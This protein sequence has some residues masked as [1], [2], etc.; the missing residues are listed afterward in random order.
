MRFIEGHNNGTLYLLLL[1]RNRRAVLFNLNIVVVFTFRDRV[2]C[3]FRFN[4]ALLLYAL[5]STSLSGL[6]VILSDGGVTGITAGLLLVR[7]Q[8]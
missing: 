1:F 5:T 8:Q 6:A 3:D 7:T 4:T 2:V